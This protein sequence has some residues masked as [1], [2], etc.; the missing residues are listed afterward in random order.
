MKPNLPPE[1]ERISWLKK[2]DRG[3]PIPWFV[4][5]VDGKPCFSVVDPQKIT[6]AW[7]GQ[8]CWICG[9]LLGNY[10]AF[11]ISPMAIITGVSSEPTSHKDCAE[12]AVQ[13]CP[14]LKTQKMPYSIP[15]KGKVPKEAFLHPDNVLHNPGIAVVWTT[16]SP[17]AFIT[18]DGVMFQ[19]GVHDSTSF[20][21][22]A[23]RA[24][25]EEVLRG[26]DEAVE[27]LLSRSEGDLSV[28]AAI[29]QRIPIARRTMENLFNSQRIN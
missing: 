21:K 2:D 15:G 22:E 27:I 6:A 29:Q 25:L 26:F 16:K 17:G 28:V 24:T 20:W 18:A 4:S 1:P 8:I 3:Y 13:A 14:F 9:Q 7:N 10:R 19:I 12:Y 5:H 23:R 11:V